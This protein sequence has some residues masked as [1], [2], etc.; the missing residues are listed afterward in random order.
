MAHAKE[1]ITANALN[2][3]FLDIE[4]IPRWMKLKDAPEQVW[5]CFS[6]KFKRDIDEIHERYTPGHYEEPIEELFRQ[7][8]SIY[9]EF[10]KVVCVS[11][12][13]VVMD[14]G[15]YKLR[16]KTFRSRDEKALLVAVAGALNKAVFVG[17]H[18]IKQFD[19]PFLCRRF[20]SM[21]MKIPQVINAMGKKPWEIFQVDTFEMWQFADFKYTV[22][23][24]TLCMVF[25][26]PSPKT[27]ITGKD[28]FDLYYHVGATD[29]LPFE[30]EEERMNAIQTYCQGDVVATV[31]VY[32]AMM[33]EPMIITENI[34]IV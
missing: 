5:E 20:L 14:N 32:L 8:A 33:N 29:E 21:G 22:S 4:T 7:K 27:G 16:I 9:A 24:D 31:N 13:M 11:L 12:G 6:K 3:I 30:G 17:G 34:V 23:L 26:V 10:G 1:V 19:C 28:V 15:M 25:N 18:N 2:T